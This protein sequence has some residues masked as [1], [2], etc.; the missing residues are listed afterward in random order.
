VQL[1]QGLSMAAS[2]GRAAGPASK[3]ARP[4]DRVNPKTVDPVSNVVNS[5]NTVLNASNKLLD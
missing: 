3:H 5:S 1:N 4:S 2:R